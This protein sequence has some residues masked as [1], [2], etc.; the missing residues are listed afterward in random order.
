MWFFMRTKRCIHCM[1]PIWED[2]GYCNHCYE[3]QKENLPHELAVGS[4]L[5]RR[6]WISAAFDGDF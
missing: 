1:E 6:Y 4:L 2:L 3:Q 5:Q